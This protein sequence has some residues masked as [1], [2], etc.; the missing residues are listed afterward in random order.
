MERATVTCLAFSLDNVWLA[1]GSDHGTVHIFKTF[2]EESDGAK[3][4]NSSSPTKKNKSKSATKMLS[5]VLPTTKKY[6]LSEEGSLAHV[7][8]IPNPVACAFVPARERSIAVAGTDE[9]V[10]GCLL[11][12]EFSS[13][14]IPPADAMVGQHNSNETELSKSGKVRRLGYHRFFRRST[15]SFPSKSKRRHQ[16]QAQEDRHNNG[17]YDEL[18]VSGARSE[19][20]S[21]IHSVARKL[22][23]VTFS[24]EVDG[25]GFDL[26]DVA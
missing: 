10:N 9:L 2:A 19:G 25:D 7:R 11:I 14:G 5:R 12:A 3:G 1:C 18:L 16:S 4:S 23:D 22:D 13:S 8:G 17:T 26:V 21:N 6:F 20:E 24:E 15:H